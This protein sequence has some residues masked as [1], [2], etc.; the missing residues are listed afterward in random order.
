M[1]RGLLRPGFGNVRHRKVFKTL[2]AIAVAATA[3]VPALAQGRPPAPLPPV[4]APSPQSQAAPAPSLE[5]RIVRPRDVSVISGS[6]FRVGNERYQVFGVR[7]PRPRG[8][9]VYERLRGRQSRAALRRLLSRGEIRIAPTGQLNALGDKIA[10]VTVDGHSV[11]RKLIDARA[12]LP[13]R[14]GGET[15]NPWCISLRRPPAPSP[16]SGASLENRR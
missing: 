4:T 7:T 6:R 3:G 10:R 8:Q 12:A 2:F 15:Y 5:P 16:G 11:A 13:R 14:L 1:L 9:C